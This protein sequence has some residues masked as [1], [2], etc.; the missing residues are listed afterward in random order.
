M[1]QRVD[2]YTLLARAVESLERDAYA[3]RGAIYD[4]EHKA[5][6]KRLISSSTPCS[7]ADIAMEEQAFRDAVRRIE[8]PRNGLQA[9]RTP[10]REPAEATWPGSAREKARAPRR[11]FP[12]GPA[13]D[14]PRA[15]PPEARREPRG[16]WDTGYEESS[17]DAPGR[18]TDLPPGKMRQNE[19]DWNGLQQK[20]RSLVRLTAGYLLAAA[21]VLGAASLG[22]AYV[23]GTIDLSWFT[24]TAAPPSQSPRAMLYEAGRSGKPFAG[25][26][27]WRTQTEPNGPAGNPDLVVTLDVEIPEQHIALAMS[28]S[29]VVDAGAGMSH[30]IELRFAKPQELPFGGISRIPNISLKGTETESGESLVGTSIDIA[31]GQ[32]M[33]GLLGV[34]DV[35]RQNVQRLRTQAW[36]DFIIVFANGAAY[37]LTVE[38][39]A[40]GERA[41][42][43]AFAKWGQ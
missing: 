22:Y 17:T 31:P 13:N 1:I 41:L 35:I 12:Q 40:S 16:R 14:S 43:E 4:R 15:P 10:P 39:G 11:E 8:F 36:L 30:L 38:K 37:T 5:L 33:F 34:E 6:L 3:A 2:Y 21:T 23:V 26:A 32:F 9:P 20:S 42:N 29:R 25:K 27:V 28:L 19:P 24:Q 7:D 18:D